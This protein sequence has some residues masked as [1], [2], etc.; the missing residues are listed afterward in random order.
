MFRHR[1][2]G[3]VAAWSLA[4]FAAACSGGEEGETTDT[5]V[6]TDGGQVEAGPTC[7]G[8]S[9]C[10]A[11]GVTCSGA[12]VVTCAPD[13][14]GCLV[15]SAVPCAD[16]ETCTE[17][18]GDPACVVVETCEDA[19]EAASTSCTGN[20]LV[21]CAVGESGCL[22]ESRSTC[23]EDENCTPSGDSASCVRDVCFGRD[24]CTAIGLRCDVNTVVEC[25]TDADGC[26]VE[27]ATDCDDGLICAVV[28][29]R[30]QCVR[31]CDDD[32]ACAE[33]SVACDDANSVVTC[34]V[35]DLGCLERSVVDCTA[36]SELCVD[37]ACV[38]P[39]TTRDLCA[40]EASCDGDTWVT[41]AEDA[42]ACLVEVSRETCAF[43]CGA[44][45]CLPDPCVVLGCD[46]ETFET[47]C[48]ADVFVSC[49]NDETLGCF[50][51]TSTDCTA[52]GDVCDDRYEPVCRPEPCGDGVLDPLWEDCDDENFVDGDGCD[53]TCRIEEGYACRL[54]AP[55]PCEEGELGPICPP[56]PT[57]TVC[58]AIA[59]G[60]GRVHPPEQC[61]DQNEDPD[62]GC[63]GC[64]VDAG[65]I[66][67]GEP[68]VCALR[69][70]GDESLQF[71]EGC[72]DGLNENF[73]GCSADCA[74]EVAANGGGTVGAE[75]SFEDALGR[76]A[77]LDETCAGVPAELTDA[78]KV[79]PI[80]NQ[81]EVDLVVNVRVQWFDT[82]GVVHWMTDE[83]F[84][85]GPRA[86]CLVGTGSA[87][88]PQEEAVVSNLARLTVPAGSKRYIVLSPAAAE[89][90][91]FVEFTTLGCGD[92]II[93]EGEQCDDGNNSSE[94]GCSASCSFE[95]G[96]DC[97]GEP[98]VCEVVV[99]GDGRIEG[100]ETCD[101]GSNLDAD[102]CSSI[103]EVESGAQCFD[104][105]SRCAFVTCGDAEIAPTFES[106]EDENTDGGDGCSAACI[107]ELAAPGE[108]VVYEGEHV[109]T[110][111]PFFRANA[112]CALDRVDTFFTVVPFTN[113]SDEARV[114]TV[115]AAWNGDGFLHVYD[116]SFQPSDATLGC[117]GGNDDTGGSLGSRVRSITVAPGATI[118]VVAS[119]YAALT[120]TGP[121]TL[122]VATAVP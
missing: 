91:Y 96:F 47:S 16:D 119:S 34:S 70:C 60:D 78:F 71:G 115:T 67:V 56:T 77:R 51:V 112:A 12:S 73:D 45:G 53:A 11:E 1:L 65:W 101:D 32:P 10:T 108:S 92:G 33:A 5:G 48:A 88:D 18:G 57:F 39:C 83:V 76:W 109:A 110:D 22:E 74:L 63:T 121:F 82:D 20:T 72:D 116:G 75:G 113:A 86:A 2:T 95:P 54:A 6:D 94:D 106:C 55:G 59:C 120:A 49:E 52:A 30:A 66:C 46:P 24:L 87:L 17:N 122:T 84:T 89:G 40:A 90:S 23:A 29:G 99:C 97:S 81:T 61:D 36:T 42:D 19:C 14:D 85:A 100:R 9:N 37:G 79:V 50:V 35:S 102:G 13:A 7:E 25:A 28:D 114:V 4:A 107:L 15:S 103:C 43:G 44:E 26:L 3:R 64:V 21:V 117:L 38:D 104:L 118:Q 68:S 27:T 58:E 93:D 105:P 41:C 8:V 62:D 111:V 31:P 69:A 98:S 80:R